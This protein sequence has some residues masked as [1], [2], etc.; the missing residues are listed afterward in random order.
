MTDMTEMGA[1]D[2]LLIEARGRQPPPPPAGNDMYDQLKKLAE[3]KDAGIISEAEFSAAK[4]KLL[5][6]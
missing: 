3:L 2:Y 6:T 5:A 4:A 1:I